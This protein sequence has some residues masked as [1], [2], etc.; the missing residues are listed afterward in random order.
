ML[1]LNQVLTLTSLTFK[2]NIGSGKKIRKRGTGKD[3]DGMLTL[4]DN[5]SGTL[6]AI[7]RVLSAHPCNLRD[8]WKS[9]C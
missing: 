5:E 2:S 9:Y 3:G 6:P 1:C 7:P 4:S 8:L